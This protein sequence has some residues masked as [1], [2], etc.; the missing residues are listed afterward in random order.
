IDAGK[1]GGA[2]T[3]LEGLPHLLAPLVSDPLDA[4]HR[5]SWLA[6]HLEWREENQ[7]A[8]P[9]IVVAIDDAAPLLAADGRKFASLL[10]ML[11]QRGPRHGVHVIAGSREPVPALVGD[12]L[13]GN[14]PAR[15][16]A[17]VS[18]AGN[19]RYY[20]NQSNSGAEQ[21]LG[22]G[23]ML[24][25]L[26]GEMVRMQAAYINEAEC[27]QVVQLMQRVAQEQQRE[28]ERAKQPLGA[29]R[30]ARDL[31]ALRPALG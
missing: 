3:P 17:K 31:A 5:L 26:E 16:V 24:V 11:C 12:N 30:P 7:V 25:V 20:T 14:F 29:V 18:S 23:D 15:I 1:R 22:A 19:A 8:S 27:A 10:K 21:L 4:V 6:R 28:Q 2:L 13:Y 9:R